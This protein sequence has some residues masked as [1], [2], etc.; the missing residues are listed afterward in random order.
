MRPLSTYH[1]FSS[2]TNRRFTTYHHSYAHKE[3]F[4]VFSIV[5]QMT[6]M[7]HGRGTKRGKSYIA[8]YIYFHQDAVSSLRTDSFI[9]CFKR[10]CGRTGHPTNNYSDNGTNFVDARRHLL[11]EVQRMFNL[12][13]HREELFKFS[14]TFGYE[15]NSN[16]PVASHFGGLW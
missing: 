5:W 14:I 2:P 1:Y 8:A 7:Y 6:T 3:A 4:S 10:F 13:V 11:T 9:A 12:Q 15:W 16:P